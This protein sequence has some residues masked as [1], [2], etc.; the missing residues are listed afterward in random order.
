MWAIEQKLNIYIFIYIKKWKLATLREQERQWWRGGGDWRWMERH[1][2]T[3]EGQA[4]FSMGCHGSRIMLGSFPWEK[5]RDE[6]QRL[7]SVKRHCWK[8]HHRT[9]SYNYSISICA[10]PGKQSESSP[11]GCVYSVS[12]RLNS[13]VLL[14][15][16]YLACYATRESSIMGQRENVQKN[17]WYVGVWEA[18]WECMFVSTCVIRAPGETTARWLWKTGITL[19]RHPYHVISLTHI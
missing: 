4:G 6:G 19:T 8:D 9:I 15:S 16:V 13:K 11:G 14:I 12:V 7:Q 2:I 1:W 3:A 10:S 17:R 18:T 5:L